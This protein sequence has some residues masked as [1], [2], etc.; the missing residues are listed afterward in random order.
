VAVISWVQIRCPTISGKAML[1]LKNEAGFTYLAMMFA[2]FLVG[3]SSMVAAQQWQTRVQREKEAELLFRGDA[4]RRA[5]YTYCR[6]AR[7]GMTFCPKSLHD[8]VKA[9]GTV[10]V[11]R[12]LRKNYKD[13]ITNGD[14]ELIKS[15]DG[16]S[17]L[18]VRSKSKAKPL[19]QGG[20]PTALGNF[21]GSQR[22]AD[23]VF[24]CPQLQT[25][26][27]AADSASQTASAVV[28]AQGC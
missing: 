5:I 2:V 27:Q 6:T 9:P 22:Y 7:A 28:S 1:P 11:R 16:R 18:G 24:I 19:K 14:W 26:T 17:V 8:L 25:F 23:W 20:F 4:I 13:P 10:A 3:L 15:R 21:A 12:Y